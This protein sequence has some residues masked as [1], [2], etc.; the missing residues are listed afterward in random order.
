MKK[1]YISA[2]GT[3][4]P[5][6]QISRDQSANF[7]ANVLELSDT[8]RRKLHVLYRATGI[9]KRHSVMADSLK[10]SDF[11]FFKENKFPTTADRMKLYETHA[12]P[13]ALEAVADCLKNFSFDFSQ[14]THLIAVSCTGMYA[15]GLDIELVGSLKLSKSVKRT[16]IN[17]MGCYGAF[18]AM[19]VAD[20]FCRAEENAKIL[21]VG[22]EMCTIHLQKSTLPDHLLSNAL[23]ADG[24]SA[25]LVESQKRPNSL[26]MSGFYAGLASE[27]KTDMAWM[28][29]DFGFDMRL[30]SYVPSILE[31]NMTDL[32][33]NLC[34]ELN[35]KWAEIEH[36]AIHPG[37]KKILEALEKV[38]KLSPEKNKSAYE[39]LRN[40]GNMSSVTIWFVLKN[41]LEKLPSSL[42]KT[43]ILAMAFGPG[44]TVESAILTYQK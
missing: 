38:L 3:A 2:I 37:G 27:G 41:L 33:E 31:Q 29:R 10:T 36:F 17:F 26:E 44:L 6:H 11:E 18:N 15:P 8:E 7:V 34:D 14:I 39:I 16:C 21:I 30:S 24:A 20:A 22:V 4:V 35:M 28:I 9:E 43:N 12:L 19:K 1:S 40:Y 32:M 42:S 13:L 23:F 25:V 5:P